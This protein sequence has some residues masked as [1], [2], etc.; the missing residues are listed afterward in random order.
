MAFT[1]VTF[2][3]FRFIPK[4][5]LIL[6]SGKPVRVGGRAF[7]ILSVLLDSPGVV[8]SKD[9]LIARVW[10]DMAV[11]E[12]NLTVH[13]THLRRALAT[14]EAAD[15]MIVNVP[16][17]GYL[18][19]ANVESST[20]QSNVPAPIADLIGRASELDTLL[21]LL[22][23]HRLVTIVG[24]GGTGKTSMALAIGQHA[25]KLH[26][27]QFVDLTSANHPALLPA[28]LGKAL[29]LEDLGGHTIEGIC[30]ALSGAQQLI[31][32]DNCEHVIDSAAA[33]AIAIL[34]SCPGVRISATSREP[35]R[36]AGEH[37]FRLRPLDVPPARPNRSDRE[38]LDY[39]A[40]Q[41]FV[42]CVAR[43]LEDFEP[44]E[45]D[46]SF[47][48]AICR[49][50][51]GLPLGLELAASRV[52]TLGLR[53]LAT[54]LENDLDLL[55]T[56]YRREVPRHESLRAAFDWSFALLDGSERKLLL[57]LTVFDDV[58]TQRSARKALDDHQLDG[59]LMDSLATLAMKSLLTLE[60]GGTEPRFRL[61]NTTRA[62]ARKK[63]IESER[64]IP[65]RSQDEKSLNPA[66]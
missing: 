43:R 39:P 52:A 33:A 27:V 47:I 55:M 6:K 45:Q 59:D 60:S 49:R 42:D 54:R 62:Y 24:E 21:Q 12:A 57:C 61:L 44:T 40:A 19:T 48:G 23:K 41:L 3:S 29:G 36:A 16:G 34:R 53:G 31:V 58:F 17:R 65:R 38:A 50:L 8:V 11:C 5:R 66:N 13:M 64:P 18:L 37:V 2:G 30:S 9:E 51:D 35:L 46:C 20:L 4:K 15:R 14:H 1:E 32:L 63:L 10:P 25:M 7:D 26:G 28:A 56:G 22:S